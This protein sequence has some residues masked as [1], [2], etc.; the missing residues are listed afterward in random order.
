M[1]EV[2]TLYN[3][4]HY[5]DSWPSHTHHL[6]YNEQPF[7]RA[8]SS[9]PPHHILFSRSYALHQACSS[10]W[11]TSASLPRWC[12]ST[13]LWVQYR[14]NRCAPQ[15]HDSCVDLIRRWCHRAKWITTSLSRN[16]LSEFQEKCNNLLSFVKKNKVFYQ[17]S[18]S[19]GRRGGRNGWGVQV[20]IVC[21]WQMF[22]ALIAKLGVLFIAFSSPS[23][24]ILW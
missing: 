5:L 21:L 7:T 17:R 11:T 19:W 22:Y 23:K 9:K 18:S 1:R 3:I 20:L 15:S 16:F 13:C 4:T 8:I 24:P 12:L 2:G 14:A 6:C 10:L